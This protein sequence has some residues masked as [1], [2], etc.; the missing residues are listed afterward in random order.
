MHIPEA[1]EVL[2]KPCHRVRACDEAVLQDRLLQNHM[3]GLL[4]ESAVATDPDG[5]ILSGGLF[6]IK[7][8]PKNGLPR[9][10]M[11]FDRRRQNALEKRVRW[12]T[13][14]SARLLRKRV[15]LP[16]QVWRGSGFCF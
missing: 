2:P 4:P 15:L 14:P 12:V 7:K 16:S 8:P 1:G 3:G 13:L 5:C 6:G 9:Q 11:I 10:R